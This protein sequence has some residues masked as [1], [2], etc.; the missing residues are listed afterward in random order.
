[1]SYKHIILLV[2]PLMMGMTAMANDFPT[3]ADFRSTSAMQ[4][5]DDQAAQGFRS[6]ATAIYTTTPA[7]GFQAISTTPIIGEDGQAINP[8]DAATGGNKAPIR[9]AIVNPGQGGNTTGPANG[10]PLGDALLPLLLAALA[11]GVVLLRRRRNRLPQ[12]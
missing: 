3:G 5:I 8:M 7:T 12:Q 9:R 6:T 1:M 10:A 11:Y 2:L 4:R